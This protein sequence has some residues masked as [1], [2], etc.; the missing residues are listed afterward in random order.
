MKLPRWTVWPAL[1]AL[2]VFISPAVPIKPSTDADAPAARMAV[3]GID[4]LDPDVLAEVMARHPDLT[5]NWK[6]LVDASGIQRLG[7]S[8]PPQSPVA[9]SNF[10]TGL[11]PGGHGVYDF[12]HRDPTTR[13]PVSSITKGE[14]GSIIPLFDGWQLPLGGDEAPNRTGKAFWTR[15]AEHGVPADIWRMPANFP[16]EP[17]DGLSFSG[18]MTPAVD[19]AY[20]RYTLYTTNAAGGVIGREGNIVPVRESQGRI[21]TALAGPPNPFRSGAATQETTPLSIYVDRGAKACAVELGGERIVLEVGEWSE[22]KPATF[23]LLPLSLSDVSGIVRFHLKSVEPHVELYV[24]PVNIDP[25]APIAPV[26]EPVEASAEVADAVGLYYTQGMPEDVNAVKDGALDDREFLGQADVVHDEGVRLMDHAIARWRANPRGG[27]LFFYMSGVDLCGHMLWRHHDEGHPHH[28]AE[29][30]RG[31]TEDWS[32]RPGST[33]KDIVE[34]LYLRMDPLV[35]RLLDAAGPDDVVVVMSDHGFASYRRKFSLN[36]WLLEQGYLV[37]HEG[38]AKELPEGDPARSPVSFDA[39]DWTRT[40]AYGL[41]FNGLYLN[42]RGRELDDPTTSEDE[43]GIVAPGAESV[44]LLVELKAK[45]EALRDDDGARVVLRADLATDCYSGP[46]VAEA[47]D[48]VVGYNENYGNSDEASS[49]RIPH[50]VLCDNDKGGT[51]NGSH[52]MAPEVVE[53]TILANRRVR[54]GAHR[55][56]DLTVEVLRRHGVAIPPELK[57][58]PVLE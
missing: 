23:G 43:S 25:R 46:R 31:S 6:R 42:Q 58:K 45:L 26:S 39:V 2:A 29:F 52:L 54:P 35:G 32:K 22:F 10:I 5:R 33:W 56:E 3:L 24:S 47:P 48:I 49:G 41:G 40:R 7:T 51:F 37:L 28:D 57:G 12:L 30:A 15:L 14:P 4:G 9:W 1:G 21:D 13:L 50:E 38:R 19:S 18:M 8:T 27:F 20:G 55:L 36:T 53:G 44:A 34:D 16:V 11:D 17:A